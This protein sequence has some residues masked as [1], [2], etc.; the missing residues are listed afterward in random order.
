[1]TRKSDWSGNGEN[2]TAVYQRPTQR[3]NKEIETELIFLRSLLPIGSPGRWSRNIDVNETSLTRGKARGRGREREN[4]D[5]NKGCVRF[6]G[7]Q[8]SRINLHSY[9][10]S[11]T[12]N[13]DGQLHW[14]KEHLMRGNWWSMPLGVSI[15]AS[16][17]RISW[18]KRHALKVLASM[19]GDGGGS[20]E[21]TNVT[22][23]ETPSSGVY[24][25]RNGHLL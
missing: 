7:D 3:G 25:A 9:G 20:R 13:F 14:E 5:V 15:K 8:C 2:V 18:R 22:P 17:E 21:S 19:A 1:M 12:V 10:Y 11:S 24:G 16:L 6:W 4:V 23:A